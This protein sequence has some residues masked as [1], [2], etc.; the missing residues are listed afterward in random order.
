[1]ETSVAIDGDFPENFNLQSYKWGTDLDG[2]GFED[3]VFRGTATGFTD[4]DYIFFVLY[5]GFQDGNIDV[6]VHDTRTLLPPE[7]SDMRTTDI[8]HA[9]QHDGSS[10]ILLSMRNPSN[11]RYAVIF[12]VD[13]ERKLEF[14]QAIEVTDYQHS[15]TTRFITTNLSG[16]GDPHL[17]V[18]SS[19]FRED[20]TFCFAPSTDEN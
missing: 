17:V 5:G 8:G 14:V 12:S 19:N 13:G 11:H 6:G 20:N 16:G 3:L 2:D 4:S 18:T 1:M 7:L 10:Y 15:A 9:F